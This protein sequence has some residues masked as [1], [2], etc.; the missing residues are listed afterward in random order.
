MS[1][2][3]CRREACRQ[4]MPARIIVLLAFVLACSQVLAAAPGDESVLSQPW[5]VLVALLV[6]L[7]LSGIF[8]GTEIALVSLSLPRVRAME[9]SGVQ[10]AH[11]IQRLKSR[12]NRM[13]I[14]ILLGNNLVNIGASVL[15]AAWTSATFGSAALGVA[16]A[17]LTLLVLVLGEIPASG[18]W[19]GIAP[20]MN[21]AIT[22]PASNPT[23]RR[24]SPWRSCSQNA[25]R[26]VS[27]SR[28]RGSRATVMS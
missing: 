11:L 6:L 24:S 20:F 5:L 4:R 1:V 16:T 14:T 8:S 3:A 21:S 10:G 7:V 22:S 13:L 18:R 15:A 26:I 12:P 27:R 9:A 2:K 25:V 23:K 19:P 28:V 17:I